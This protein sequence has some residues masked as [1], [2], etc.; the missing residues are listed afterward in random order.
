MFFLLEK[1]EK[2]GEEEWEGHNRGKEGEDNRKIEWM[3]E[4][5][6]EKKITKVSWGR[7]KSIVNWQTSKEWKK[8]QQRKEWKKEEKKTFR[9]SFCCTSEWRIKSEKNPQTKRAIVL[10]IF[11]VY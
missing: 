5:K 1:W 2:I 3:S 10:T 6:L 4:K 7:N 8:N 11:H 9:K